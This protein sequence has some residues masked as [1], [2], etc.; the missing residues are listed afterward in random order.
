MKAI[1]ALQDD[2]FFGVKI[3]HAAKRAGLSVTFVKSEQAVMEALAKTPAILIVDLNTPSV[4]PPALIGR[5]KSE[6]PSVP[7]IGYV[8][9]VQTELRERASAAGF[10]AVLPRSVFS[11]RLEEILRQ[12]AGA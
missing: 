11:A 1:I 3:E 12:H 2:L 7:A 10:D 9:H 5:V 8:S 6:F 4:D